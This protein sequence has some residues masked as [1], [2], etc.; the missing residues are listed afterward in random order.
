MTAE[1]SMLTA[2]GGLIGTAA[3][4]VLGCVVMRVVVGR[5]TPAPGLRRCHRCGGAVLRNCLTCLSAPNGK[6]I[7]PQG[8]SSSAP[9]QHT[10]S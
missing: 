2:V 6:L 3:G 4:V 7:P 8:G 1:Q 9:P 10:R 5:P